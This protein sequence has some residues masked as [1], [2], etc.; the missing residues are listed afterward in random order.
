MAAVLV[1]IRDA[2]KSAI[3]ANHT[4]G[5]G[6]YDLSGT[7]QVKIGRYLSPPGSAA[8]VAIATPVP[9]GAPDERTLRD[10]AYVVAID[11]QGWA[12]VSAD[13]P[14]ARSTAALNLMSDILSAVKASRYDT[15]GALKA[16]NAVRGIREMSIVEVDGE[17]FE[18]PSGW[19]SVFGTVVLDVH[20]NR[21]L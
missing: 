6:T 11:L 1:S 7:D 15:G 12:P 19:A 2:V 17:E 16:I 18:I 8:F 20:L 3:A 10:H 21:G 9:K 5:G 14:E 13:T 4:S